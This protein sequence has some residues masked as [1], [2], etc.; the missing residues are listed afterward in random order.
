M[1]RRQGL[2]KRTSPATP[3][4]GGLVSWGFTGL[5]ETPVHTPQGQG[6]S[7]SC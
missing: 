6:L 3:Q 4:P 1:G 7:P 2:G 5:R